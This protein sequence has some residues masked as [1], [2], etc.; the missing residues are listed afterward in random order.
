MKMEAGSG[1]DTCARGIQSG[2]DIARRSGAPRIANQR[3]RRSSLSHMQ[4]LVTYGKAEQMRGIKGLIFL[5]CLSIVASRT[6]QNH[7]KST[8]RLKIGNG[9]LKTDANGFDLGHIRKLDCL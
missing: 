9:S 6:P 5:P 4:P 3:G 2:G 8:W 7:N 1:A